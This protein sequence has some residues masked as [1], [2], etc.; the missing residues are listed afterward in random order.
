MIFWKKSYSCYCKTKILLHLHKQLCL[1]YHSK[2]LQSVGNIREETE[3][4]INVEAFAK[5]EQRNWWNA[6]GVLKCMF[7]GLPQCLKNTTGL[8][9]LRHFPYFVHTG[10]GSLFFSSFHNL[11]SLYIML[12]SSS[13][14]FLQ[15]ISLGVAYVTNY[16][17]KKHANTK[18]PVKMMWYYSGWRSACG[19]ELG[20]NLIYLIT[21]S[22]KT[23]EPIIAITI[24]TLSVLFYV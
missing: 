6:L 5:C 21:V 18:S 13:Q 15:C 2:H 1:G 24:S 10:H 11:T 4:A 3:K 16:M 12:S 14:T 22:I 20:F 23:L 17:W 9:L 7:S 8:S 19:E